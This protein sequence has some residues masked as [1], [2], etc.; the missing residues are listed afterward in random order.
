MAQ[1]LRGTNTSEC[2]RRTRASVEKAGWTRLD[3]DFF[4]FEQGNAGHERSSSPA[5]KKANVVPCCVHNSVQHVTCQA[6]FSLRTR[7]SK[8][9]SS[10]TLEPILVEGALMSDNEEGGKGAPSIEAVPIQT[11]L[12]RVN[13]VTCATLT[14]IIH[15]CVYAPLHLAFYT[16]Y[17]TWIS[18]PPFK[19][20]HGFGTQGG[21]QQD[22]DIY[23]KQVT[24][25]FSTLMWLSAFASTLK[26]FRLC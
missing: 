8:V 23:W 12:W 19:T 14:G 15:W 3:T 2:S 26:N 11:F 9:L 5:W 20:A 13:H 6:N 17:S 1:L 18:F 22:I 16:P 10:P 7:G 4:R 21:L 25:D 24:Y